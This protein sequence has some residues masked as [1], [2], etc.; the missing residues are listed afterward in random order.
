MSNS[1]QITVPQLGEGVHQVRIVKILKETGDWVEE[2]SD[3]IEIETDKATYEVPAPVSGY[4]SS[5]ICSPGQKLDVGDL[6]LE[7]NDNLLEGAEK[8][9]PQR[10]KSEALLKNLSLLQKQSLSLSQRQITLIEQMQESQDLVIPA[11][12][13]R[14]I[15]WGKIETIRK[16]L[17]QKSEASVPSSLAII[18]FSAAQ[19]MFNYEKFR[20]KLNHLNQLEINENSIIGLAVSTGEDELVM[21]TINVTKDHSLYDVSTVTDQAVQ[22]AKDASYTAS[23]YHSLSI[24]SLS[25]EG[26]VSAKPIVVYPSVATLFIGTPYYTLNK[27]GGVIKTANLGLTF[28]HRLINGAYAAKFLAEVE[29][30]FSTLIISKE[31]LTNASA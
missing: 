7:I 6:M 3:L 5:I 1:F 25:A 20:G 13:E 22:N 31:E 21:P 26:I 8:F 29:K 17:R 18:A 30:F 12:I 9:I 16:S 11:T 14:P 19:A 2:D 24:S 4:I 28:D 23:G 15:N 10:R 27:N